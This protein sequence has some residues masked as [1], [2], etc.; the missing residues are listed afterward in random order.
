MNVVTDIYEYIACLADD[1][2]T[3]NMLSVNK[4]FLDENY[5]RRIIQKKYPYLAKIKEYEKPFELHV[6]AGGEPKM[7]NYVMTWRQCY[8]KNLHFILTIENKYGIPYFNVKFYFPERLLH[9]LLKEGN[10]YCYLLHRALE[11]GRSDIRDDI[12]QKH[13]VAPVYSLLSASCKSG[14]LKLV[15]ETYNFLSEKLKNPHL[16]QGIKYAV[17]HNH[18]DILDFLLEK[19]AQRPGV[20]VAF[21]VENR[22]YLNHAL[23]LSVFNE[24][25]IMTKYLISKGANNFYQCVIV[26][27]ERINSLQKYKD[28][29]NTEKLKKIS[30][31]QNRLEFFR[32]LL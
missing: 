6:R 2:T 12:L 4:K 32:T 20:G 13:K 1:T 27:Q 8:I 22:D 25:N 15:K 10:P 18:F 30:S 26:L 14:N 19:G 5:Y 28:K 11:Q 9:R 29:L 23:S 31:L 17:R 7:Y 16:N 24:S 21:G 3:L